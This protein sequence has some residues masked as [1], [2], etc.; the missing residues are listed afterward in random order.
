MTMKQTCWGQRSMYGYILLA[1]IDNVRCKE[2]RL[3][4]T[5]LVLCSWG[6]TYAERSH[7]FETNLSL[8]LIK[9]CDDKYSNQICVVHVYY[10]KLKWKIWEKTLI[11]VYDNDFVTFAYS[12][13]G[14]LRIH[15]A[16]LG[17][18]ST[19]S[20]PRANFC[21]II[22]FQLQKRTFLLVSW[23]KFRIFM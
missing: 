10:N 5:L 16:G 1:N 15:P 19:L 3:P 12:C 14:R 23:K 17:P 18:I 9:R 21:I 4:W 8:L 20:T 22:K 13:Q 11:N 2:V 7:V 6:A